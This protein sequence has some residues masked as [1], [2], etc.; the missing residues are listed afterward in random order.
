MVH[1]NDREWRR[2]RSRLI[3]G[4]GALIAV[5]MLSAAMAIGALI[6][7]SRTADRV[8][9][10]AV[11]DLEAVHELELAAEQL[12]STAKAYLL[13]GD[14]QY[15]EQFHAREGEIE[16]ALSRLRRRETFA[17]IAEADE[18][19]LH[20]RGYATAVGRVVRERREAADLD[21]VERLFH[22]LA[23]QR[24]GF[25]AAVANL[26]DGEEQEIDS[27]AIRAGQL[28]GATGFALVLACVFGVA[29][30]IA[31]AVIVARRLAIQFRSVDEATRAAKQAADARKELLD[32]VSHDLRAPLST[33]TLGL[34]VLR[35][36]HGELEHLPRVERAAERMARLIDDLL[37]AARAESAGLA[38]DPQRCEARALI[39]AAVEQFADRA[40]RD[41]VT[42][43]IEAPERC[44]FHADRDRVV[45]V[46]SNL[47]GN[48]LGFTSGGGTIVV[49]AEPGDHELRFSVRDTGPGIEPE[50][51]A[52]LFEPYRQGGGGARRGRLGLGLHICRVFVEAHGGRIGVDSAPGEGS[53]FW[54]TIPAR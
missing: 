41:G 53:T 47:I 26:V 30:S 21:T 14:P 7:T 13:T 6:A 34:D 38:L 24:A 44:A 3:V 42:L 4:V 12:Q 50:H 16:A 10:R 19:A 20:A 33:I 25:H 1:A 5:T 37:D 51:T 15:R 36:Q 35:E 22:D 48:A 8:S 46:L 11:A 17:E 43:R 49:A 27:S 52:R 29:L 31:L 54:F 39:V 23:P 32:I 2:F 28:I 18:V 9:H 45:Q 40:G